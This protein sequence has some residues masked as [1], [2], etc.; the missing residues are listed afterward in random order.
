MRRT[1]FVAAVI[2]LC[3]APGLALA[4]LPFFGLEAEPTHARIGEPITI[5]MTCFEDQEH[6]RAQ[7]TCFGAGDSMAWVH[8]L[9]DD[10]TFDRSDWIPVAGQQ[11]VTGRIQGQI[12]LNEPGAYDVVPLWRTWRGGQSRGF[13]DP[14][15]IEVGGDAR[16]AMIVAAAIGFV[17]LSSFALSRRRRAES[18]TLSR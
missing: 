8:P 10:G 16:F 6:T 11:T 4:K 2:A 7:P 12:V 9:D 5:T 18:S 1:L 13:P 17:S 3:T 14:I 15:R